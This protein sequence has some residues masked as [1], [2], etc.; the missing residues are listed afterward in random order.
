MSLT[1]LPSSTRR[2]SRS[3]ACVVLPLRSSPS[4]TI[5]APLLVA[6]A[7]GAPSAADFGDE[8]LAMAAVAKSLMDAICR[9]K[10]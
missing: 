5:K 4:S 7:D 3:L 2:C 9:E 10:I 1:G 8:E 6:A